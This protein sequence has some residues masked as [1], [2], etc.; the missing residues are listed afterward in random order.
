MAAPNSKFGIW[1][2]RS[3]CIAG[4]ALTASVLVFV[5]AVTMKPISG[6]LEERESVVASGRPIA[7][8]LGA[9]IGALIVLRAERSELK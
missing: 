1:V 8:I 7:A 6:S 4:G 3:L 2:R 5:Y 9:T